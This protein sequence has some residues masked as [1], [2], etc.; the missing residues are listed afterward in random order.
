MSTEP[1]SLRLDAEAKRK[2][3]P[4]FEKLGLKPAQAINFFLH[5][6]AMNHG[7]PFDLKIP[8]AETISA[9]NETEEEKSKVFTDT[10][11]FFEDLERD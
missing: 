1:T 9:M 10:D 2:A 6:V 8:N 3:Y 11:E 5:Q 4:I 7:L